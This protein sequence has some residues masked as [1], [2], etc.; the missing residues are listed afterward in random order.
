M[1]MKKF[2]GDVSPVRP[3]RLAFT[4]CSWLPDAYFWTF[5]SLLVYKYM[6]SRHLM[7]ICH[8]LPFVLPHTGYGT[9]SSTTTI[10]SKQCFLSSLNLRVNHYERLLSEQGLHVPKVP[11]MISDCYLLT[12]TVRILSLHTL[13]NLSFCLIAEKIRNLFSLPRLCSMPMKI[14]NLVLSGVPLGGHCWGFHIGG[15]LMG[16]YGKSP[17]S[18]CGADGSTLWGFSR[19]SQTSCFHL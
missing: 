19:A 10:P 15:D 5:W 4:C 14:S 6:S 7:T 13:N 18:T 11:T 3:S 17:T 1:A 2:Q 8:A 16:N 9:H 12:Y